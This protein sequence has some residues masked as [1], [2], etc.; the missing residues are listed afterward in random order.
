MIELLKFL[1]LMLI[2]AGIG[3]VIGVGFGIILIIK[4]VRK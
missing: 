4:A 3:I 2:A 1:E